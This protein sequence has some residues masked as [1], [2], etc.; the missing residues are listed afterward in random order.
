MSWKDVLSVEDVAEYIRLVVAKLMRRGEIP[1]ADFEIRP[2]PGWGVRLPVELRV[3][4]DHSHFQIFDVDQAG[5][6][7]T[8]QPSSSFTQFSMTGYMSAFSIPVQ[9][10]VRGTPP[11][12]IW[13]S[14]LA[15][16]VDVMDFESFTLPVNANAAFEHMIQEQL[17]PWLHSI[18]ERVS[19]PN[20]PFEPL[21]YVIALVGDFLEWQNREQILPKVLRPEHVESIK[22]TMASN[23][24]LSLLVLERPDV[25]RKIFTFVGHHYTPYKGESRSHLGSLLLELRG[26]L[27]R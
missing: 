25:G 18:R 2:T 10:Y 3:L 9:E 19:D 12:E 8:R 17:P 20:T 7:Y 15:Q 23:P 24:A 1:H 11:G 27:R 22:A 5:D 26:L 4:R 16:N 14:P 13:G 6:T 21:L